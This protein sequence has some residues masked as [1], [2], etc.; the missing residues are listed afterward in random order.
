MAL[1]HA[2]LT[3]L[4]FFAGLPLAHAG[5]L[6]ITP[7]WEYTSSTLGYD[8]RPFTVGFK[9]SVSSVFQVNA[10]GYYN[11]GES[12]DHPVALW[13]TNGILLTST[14]VSQAE[15]LEGH[16]RWNQVSYSLDPGTYV[17]G[18]LYQGNYAPFP[19]FIQGVTI[20]P[21]YTWLSFQEI[22]G[23]TLA[24]PDQFSGGASLYGDNGVGV[25]NLSGAATPEPA[26]FLLLLAGLI[27]LGGEARRKAG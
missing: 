5:P 6:A 23:A 4:L 26:S 18:G 17:I 16:F 2:S 7:I 27:G 14:V 8:S 9:F 13:D 3:A 11:D 25:V 24:Y 20:L 22:V 15:P 19:M 10:L 21:G 1:R 12:V